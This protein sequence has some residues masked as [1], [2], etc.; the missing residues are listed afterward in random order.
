MK[1]LGLLIGLLLPLTAAAQY[2]PTFV[3]QSHLLDEQ[4]RFGAAAWSAASVDIDGDGRVDIYQPGR[5]YLNTGAGEDHG[6]AF[7]V[8]FTA[9]LAAMG[10]P[11]YIADR[12]FGASWAD[13][14]DDGFPEGFESVLFANGSRFYENH[15]GVQLFESPDAA[16]I[17]FPGL[18]QGA[19]FADYNGDGVLDVFIGDDLGGSRLY[20]GVP[21][22]H[23]F[24]TGRFE[25]SLQNAE[26]AAQLPKAYGLA[27]AD[28]DNDGDIDLFIG[29]CSQDNPAKSVNLLYRN[30]GDGTFDEVGAAAGVDDDLAA[31]GV[32]WLD[33]DRDGWLDIYVVNM[34]VADGRTG[35]NLLYRNNGD[36]TF[37]ER[38][39]MAGVAGSPGA[40]TFGT[41]AVDVNNDGWVDL[42]TAGLEGGALYLNNADG[43]FTDAIT[44]AGLLY[45]PEIGPPQPVRNQAITVGDYNADGWVD[46]F[47]GMNFAP[48]NRLLMNTPGTNH[49]LTVRLSQPAPNRDAVGARLTLYAGDQSPAKSGAAAAQSQIREIA[50]GDGFVSQNLAMT[51]HFGLGAHALVDSLVIRWPDGERQT[52]MGIQAD[53]SVTIRKGMGIDAPP[54]AA[55]PLT[56][57]WTGETVTLTWAEGNDAS[58]NLLYTPV[59]VHPDG[60]VQAGTPTTAT[61]AELPLTPTTGGNFR[62]TVVTTDGTTIRRARTVQDIWLSGVATSAPLELPDAARLGTPYPNPAS[63]ALS[64]DIVTQ[65]AGPEELQVID[66]LGRIVL[67][68]RGHSVSGRMTWTIDTSTL[69]PGAYLLRQRG[70][71][72]ARPFIIRRP[73][74][75]Q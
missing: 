46:V 41:S 24:A 6:A 27:A 54:T 59:I 26:F 42:H 30:R 17:A 67:R 40:Q 56:L 18:A 16:G 15:Y 21:D 52:I 51:A 3:D 5:L 72:D 48:Y 49:Y 70:S 12:V 9:S 37:E 32:V 66:I 11:D 60:T 64:V 22:E 74:G 75:R 34:A 45:Q 14:D 53:R 58:P 50:A 2:V 44:E 57:D 68:E 23:G 73:D 61:Q 1:P 29:A 36:G 4:T 31:W 8:A 25:P 20:F 63:R 47:T 33:Y 38:G 35:E 62:W 13:V 19:A 43:T 7:D 10:L 39:A 28:Y 65:N 55:E 71:N 69:A